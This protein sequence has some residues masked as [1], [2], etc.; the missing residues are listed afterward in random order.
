[1]EQIVWVDIDRDQ[2]RICFLL[3]FIENTIRYA[4]SIH[5]QMKKHYYKEPWQIVLNIFNFSKM[6]Y[7]TLMAEIEKVQIVLEMTNTCMIL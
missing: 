2:D 5:F 4:N 1:M 7:D 6:L 3:S